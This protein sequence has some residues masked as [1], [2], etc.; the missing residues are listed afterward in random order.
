MRFGLISEG[1]TDHKVLKSI[2]MGLFGDDAKANELQ[3]R[4]GAQGGWQKVLE[5]C[6]SGSIPK[7]FEQ[8]DFLIIQIDTDRAHETGFEVST[9]D[10]N[11]KKL[12]TGIII[13]NVKTKIIPLIK[14]GWNM[15]FENYENRIIFAIAIDATECWLLTRFESKKNKFPIE[16]A[17]VHHLNK[18]LPTIV[19]EKDKNGAKIYEKEIIS[20]K[21]DTKQY[22]RLAEPFSEND[23]LIEKSQLNPSFHLFLQDL[24]HK[25]NTVC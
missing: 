24:Q 5:Y 12:A 6:K 8:N 21:K 1:N 14:E 10:E 7:N 22:A 4:G 3:P 16:N 20:D 17:C 2:L 15:D 11:N 13:A 19:K 9:R 18:I 25:T 23:I